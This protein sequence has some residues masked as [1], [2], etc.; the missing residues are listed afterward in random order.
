VRFSSQGRIA[1]I[2]HVSFEAALVLKA[3]N[4]AFEVLCGLAIIFV[5]PASANELIRSLTKAE[6]AEDPKDFF[7]NALV[8]LGGSYTAGAQR[9]GMVY[10][11]SHGAL[12]LAI[13]V[14]LMKGKLWAYPLAVA[15]LGVF[16]VYQLIMLTVT[17]SLLLVLLTILDLAVIALTLLEYRRQRFS[18]NTKKEL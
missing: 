2:F 8:H 18:Q 10:L 16:V 5:D 1:D 9:F 12:K 6:L 3:L 14:L 13:V 11:L 4:A 7:A 15:M 17:P